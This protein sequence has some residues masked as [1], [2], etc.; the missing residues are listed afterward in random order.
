MR[1]RHIVEAPRLSAHHTRQ[2]NM[3]MMML[4][5]VALAHAILLAPRPVVDEMQQPGISKE[6]QRAEDGGLVDG[7]EQIL[8]IAERKGIMDMLPKGAGYGWP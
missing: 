3:T 7:D 8:H 6:G 1:N 4:R 5:V 2:M